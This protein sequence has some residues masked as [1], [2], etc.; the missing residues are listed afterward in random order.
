MGNEIARI[1]SAGIKRN[2]KLAMVL[3]LLVN[4]VAQCL[5]HLCSTLIVVVDIILESRLKVGSCL[6]E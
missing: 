4:V 5:W 2:I 1:L 3:K 6:K